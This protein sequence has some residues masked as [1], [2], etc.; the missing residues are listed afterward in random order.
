METHVKKSLPSSVISLSIFAIITVF[1]YFRVNTM[2]PAGWMG[3]QTPSTRD[4]LLSLLIGVF[5]A[6]LIYFVA[7][8]VSKKVPTLVNPE[9]Q[10]ISNP[11][12][13]FTKIL[14]LVILVV[15]FEETVFRGFLLGYI[16]PLYGDILALLLS[17]LLFFIARVL[18]YP[19]KL[20]KSIDA[21]ALLSLGIL[22]LSFGLPI[23]Y[24]QFLYTEFGFP[25]VYNSI[26]MNLGAS[27]LFT[28]LVL[29]K[30]SVQTPSIQTHTATGTV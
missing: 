27:L 23:V 19:I 20:G 5:F 8:I 28:W 9:F 16:T 13:T 10:A 24:G 7:D 29:T 1:A 14:P 22:A 26:V 6:F 25:S 15:I 11:S 4:L 30:M 2:Y 17:A 3:F 21:E 18:F 12:N